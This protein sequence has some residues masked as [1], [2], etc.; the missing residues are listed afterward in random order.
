MS[1]YVINGF[2][3]IFPSLLAMGSFTQPQYITGS[4]YCQKPLHH[5]Y[6]SLSVVRV[7]RRRKATTA[8]CNWIILL[9]NIP[10]RSNYVGT[11]EHTHAHNTYTTGSY[12][13]ELM[14]TRKTSWLYQPQSRLIR[15]KPSKIVIT[16]NWQARINTYSCGVILFN[17]RWC[18]VFC[19]Q[20][21]KNHAVI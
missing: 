6:I 9:P 14:N 21:R 11:V 5:P 3:V 18:F 2:S 13:K 17:Y 15:R 16:T 1:Y 20:C 12:N 19:G 7:A 10:T 8:S 4:V